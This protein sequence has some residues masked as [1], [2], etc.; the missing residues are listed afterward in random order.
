MYNTIAKMGLKG[1]EGV[2]NVDLVTA[3]HMKIINDK[4]A[5]EKTKK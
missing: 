3:E 2:C 1:L 4:R 5:K